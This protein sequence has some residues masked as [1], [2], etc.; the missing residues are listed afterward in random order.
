MK[1]KAILVSFLAF[2]AIAFALSTVLAD[3]FV[4]ITEVRVN[5]VV[6]SDSSLAVAG[7][8]SDTVPIE[9]EFKAFEDVSNVKV[10]VSIE[11]Y[12]DDITASTPRFHV[13]NG[14]RYIKRF[15]VTFPSTMDLDDLTE[16]AILNV[17]I[18]AKEADSVEED[19]AIELQRILYSLNLLSI[20]A[21]EKVTAGS[22]LAVDVVLQ[23]NGN[24]R[25]DNTYVKASIPEL[26]V[27]RKVY[28]GDL[29]PVEEETYD[30]IRDSTNKVLYL[31]IPRNANPGTYN[32]VVEA[33]NYDTSTTAK[34]KIVVEGVQTGV[35]PS[36]T[37]SKAIAIGEETTFDVVLVNPND[38]M[39]VYSIVPEQ[40]KGLVVEVTEPVV[41]VA[42]DSS[43]TVKVKV[44][45]TNSAEEGTHLVSVNVN[46]ES[47]L[48]RKVDFTVSV[49]KPSTGI[50]AG[51]TENNTVLILT[52]I[53]VIIF[54][55]L[56][57]VLIVLLT[58][59]PAETEEF[60]E[61]SYY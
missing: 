49:E 54:V 56:L 14:S 52:V 36:T 38:R 23:N 43:R 51:A 18:S 15:A 58:K 7:E 19:Y 26:G 53:L 3:D 9:V 28:F 29:N 34:K 33:Y 8:V 16:S 41:T 47:G 21:N 39:V 59:R 5:G 27:E 4:E 25:L 32:I 55:V 60:G 24:E 48:E 61:T 57:I 42:A 17:E 6:V 46:S 2:F 37:A 50:T 13:V 11:G 10:K 12:K 20:D 1:S 44:K 31:S 40:A 22:T 45:A 30:N 35:L